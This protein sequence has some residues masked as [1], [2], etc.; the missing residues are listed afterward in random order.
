MNVSPDLERRVA[1]WIDA[2]ATADGSELVLAAALGQA[3][4]ARQQRTARLAWSPILRRMARPIVVAVSAAT[5]LI[6]VAVTAL[7]PMTQAANAKVTGVWATGPDVAFVAE[8]PAD[9][10][11]GMYWRV[12]S[13]DAWSPS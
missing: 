4:R 5:S 11:A 12:M 9:A 1:A 10:P 8:V 2:T 7:P 13:Y 3:S 6:V